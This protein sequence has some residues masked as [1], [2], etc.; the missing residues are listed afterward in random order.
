MTER[1]KEQNCVYQI[2]SLSQNED[3]SARE[4]FGAIVNILPPA[5]LMPE[6]TSVML[7]YDGECYY[8]DNFSEKSK[9]QDFGFLQTSQENHS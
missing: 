2:T 4:Y 6:Q 3:L 5:F 1:L 8:S 7:Y 9:K